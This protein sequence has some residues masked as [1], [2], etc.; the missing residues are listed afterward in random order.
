MRLRLSKKQTA[1]SLIVLAL[2]TSPSAFGESQNKSYPDAAQQLIDRKELDEIK[3]TEEMERLL[4]REQD[5]LEQKKREAEALVSL[6]KQNIEALKSRQE[7][8][9]Q[10]IEILSVELSAVTQK[11]EALEAE[12]AKVQDTADSIVADLVETERNLKSKQ[13]ELADRFQALQ[14]ARDK[15]QREIQ[16]VSLNIQRMSSEISKVEAQIADSES[17]RSVIEAEEMKVRTEWLQANQQ[18][19]DREDE[20]L[21]AAQQTDEAARKLAKAK[22]E[23]KQVRD[24]LQKIDQETTINL[25]Q[26]RSQISRLESEISDSNRARESALAQ[27]KKLEE[28]TSRLVALA[29]EMKTR[30]DLAKNDQLEAEGILMKST[31]AYEKSKTDV[32][33]QKVAGDISSS[34]LKRDQ[35]RSRGLASAEEA[36]KLL[37]G[38]RPWVVV[39]QCKVYDKASESSRVLGKYPLGKKLLGLEQQESWVKLKGGS[40][41]FVYVKRDCGKFE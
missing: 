24:D 6:K 31:V 10:E 18:I 12:H 23:L 39:N 26:A 25:K 41:R 29:D 16:K 17:R 15:A 2:I 5:R 7:K 1:F 28:E 19:Q 30:R 4:S 3:R 35:A 38:M 40:G 34:D 14:Y 11:R 36:S 37:E 33:K 22:S 32:V 9:R 20:R 27:S 8:A 21:Q 13:T